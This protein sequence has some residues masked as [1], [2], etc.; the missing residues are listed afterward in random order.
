MTNVDESQKKNMDDYSN[1]KQKIAARTR[2]DAGN[3]QQRDFTDEVYTN[4]VSEGQF[5]ESVGS[6]NFCNVLIVLQQDRLDSFREGIAGMMERWYTSIDASDRKRVRDQGRQRFKDIMAVHEKIANQLEALHEEHRTK[7][8]SLDE[9][10]PAF[11]RITDETKA[12][13]KKL[14]E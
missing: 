8:K 1:L 2:K 12:A 5:I 3:L 7:T 11:K 4:N 6:E 9:A 13:E 14:K 10:A